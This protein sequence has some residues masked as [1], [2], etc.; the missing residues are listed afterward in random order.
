MSLG[1]GEG[2]QI[3]PDLTEIGSKLSREAMFESILYPSAGI[4]HSYETFTAELADGNV[5][6]GLKVSETR[7]FTGIE[8]QRRRRPP[9]GS[10]PN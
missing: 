3:G 4:S 6:T 10:R 8:E 9:V 1:A 5:V 2:K 7:R